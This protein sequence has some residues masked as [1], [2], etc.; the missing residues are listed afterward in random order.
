MQFSIFTSKRAVSS[1]FGLFSRII[2]ICAFWLLTLSVWGQSAGFNNTFIILS[3]NG[4]ANT[5]Y[6][7]NAATG[8]ADFN[9]ANLGS[10]AAGTNNLIFKGAEHNVFKC[11]GADLTSTRVYYRIYLTS[12][13]NS[14][15]NFISNNIPF[16]SGFNNGCGGQD[17]VWLKNDYSTNLLSGLAPGAYTI[18]VYSD[19]STTLGDKFASNNGNNYT[20]TFTIT[21]NYYSKSTGNLELTSSW[22]TN[23]DGTGNAPANFTTAGNTFNIRNNATPTIGASWTVSGTGSKIVV[24]DGTNACNFT[25]ASTF[26]VTSPNTDISNNGTI[27]R[28]SSVVQSLGSLNVLAGGTYDHNFATGSLPNATWAA[29]STLLV[30]ADLQSNNFGGVTFGN[31]TFRNT[32]GTTMF[33]GT[34]ALSSTIAG[35]LNLE[36]TGTIIM[37]SQLSANGTLTVNGNVTIS[38]NSIFRIESVALGSGSNTKTLLVLGNY[39]QSN[40]TMDLSTNTSTTMTARFAILEVRGDF[41]HT[42]GTL[43]ENAAGASPG[44]T[45]RVLL[46]KT[47]GTQTLESTGQ[48]GSVNFNVAGSNAQCVVAATKTFVLGAGNMTVANGSSATDLLVDGT[49]RS[50]STITTT[51][52]VTFSSTGT[53]EH[54]FTTTAGTIPT[55]TW[56]SGSTCAIVGY[57]S[58]AVTINSS[59]G[60]SFSNFT[61]NCASQSVAI[62]LLGILTTVNGNFVLQDAGTGSITYNSNSPATPILTIGGNCTI[63]ASINLNNG[64]ST[65]TFNIGGNFSHTGGTISRAGAGVTTFNFNKSSG[66]QTFTQSGGTITA[67]ANWNVGTGTSTNTVQLSSNVNLGTGTGTF[68]VLGNAT[69]DA[70]TNVLSGSAA[71]TFNSGATIITA[72]ASGI[73]GSITLSGTR[74][75]NAATNYTFNGIAAQV[76]GAAVT[77]A[78]NLILNNSAGLNLSANTSVTGTVTLTNGKLTLDAFDLTLGSAASV[79][80]ATSTKYIVTNSTGQLKKSALTTAFSFPVG[81]S[82]Y[83]PISIT[84]S[85]TSDTYGIIV[86][87]GAVANATVSDECVNRRWF[88]TEVT[89]GGGNLTVSPQYSTG[90]TGA[91][92]S[93]ESQ[94]YV[95]LYVPTNWT[96]TAATISGSNPFNASAS[97]F[98]QSL[99]SSSYFAIGNEGIYIAAPT[100]T[101]TVA[102]SSITNTTASSGGET[103]TGSSITSKGVVWHTS[104]APTVA[105]STKTNDGTGSTNFTSS[106]TSLSP[107]TFYYLR[108]YVTNAAGTG[109]GDEKTFRTLSNPAT[110][111]ASSLIATATS[112]SNID[113][114]WNAATFPSSGATNKGYLLLR[115]AAPNTPSLGNSNGAAPTA[116]ANSTI[117][118]SVIA[119]NATSISN[120]GLAGS[121]QYNYLLIPYTWDGTNATTYNYLTASAPTANATTQSGSTPPVLTTN[122]A[123]SV[124]STTTALNGEIT[125]DGG[126]SVTARGFVYSTSDNTPTIGEGSVND[127]SSGSGIGVFSENVSS[128][129]PNTTYYYQ[130]YATNTSGTSYGGVI[131]FTTLKAEPSAQ[132][133]SLVFSSV[134]TTSFNTAFTAATGSPDGYLVIRSTS[135]SLSADPVDGTTYTSGNSLG[136]GTVVSVGSTISGISNTSLSAG[137]TYYT[138]VFAYNNSGSN[139]DYR[140]TSPLSASTITLTDAPATPTFSSITTSGFTVDWTATTGASSYKLDV[141]TA[142]NFATFVSG[143]QDLTVNTNSQAVT[144]LSANTLYYVRVRAVNASGTSA[145]STSGNTPTLSN[146]P[147]VGTASSIT[148]S[149]LT[150]NWTAP[151]SQ[152]AVTFTYTAELSTASD[153]STI[154]ST[155][156]SIA[157]GTISNAFSSLAEGTTY[158]YRIKAV[159]SAGSSAWSSVSVGATTLS[160][161]ISLTYL[162]TSVNENFDAMS[163]STTLPSGW[164]IHASAPSPS[165]SSASTTVTQEASTGTPTAGGTYNWGTSTSERAVGAMTSGSFGSPNQL[166]VFTKNN[167]GS[168][169]TNFLIG[170][171]AERYRRNSAAASVNFYYSTNGTTW[172]EVT[173]GQI[174]SSNFPTGSSSYTFSTPLEIERTFIISGLTIASA[175][176]FYLRWDINTTGASSQG[177]G[178]DDISIKPCGTVSAPT[179]SNQ[180]FCS[181]ASPTVASLTA[182]GTSI[183]WYSAPSGGTA[184]NSSTALTTATTYYATQ[185]DG[186]CESVSRTAVVVTIN[187]T[188]SVPTG[189]ATQIF[190]STSSPTVNELSA[191]GTSIQWYEASTGGSALATNTSL[192]NS[193]IYYAT[194]TVSGCESTIRLAVT[195]SLV[196]NGTWLG[197][198]STDWNTASN[199]CGGV[200]T[201]STNVVI[202]SGA[203]NYPN[204]ST[205][206]DGVANSITINSGASLTIGG[207]E[208]LTI[209]DGG[210]FTNN[211]TFTAGSGTTLTFAG[212]GSIVGTATFNNITTSGALT[213]SATTTINGAL[214]INS[215][216]TIATNSPIFGASS[217]LQYNFGGG[218]AGRRNAGLEWPASNGPSNLTITNGS[219]IQLTGDRSL[220]GNVTVTNGALQA[221]GGRSLTMNGSTQTFTISTSSG[222]AVYGTDNGFGNDLSLVIANG[223]V[224]TLTG[225]ATSSGDDEKKFL[226][227]TVNAGG[228]LSLSRGILC[229]YGTFTV[230]GTLRI[231][232]NGYIQSTSG[233]APTYG[234]ASNLIYNTGNTFGRGLEWSSTSGAGYPNNV[235]I[236]NNTILNLGNGGTA[237]ARQCA[238]SLTVDNGSTLS[239]NI[240]A[241]SQALTIKGKYTNNGTTILSAV[242]GGDLK[243]EGDM[244]DNGTFTAN[245]RA[246]FF[247]GGNN[248]TVNSSSNPLDIDVMRIG[249]TGGEV[250]LSQN[251]LVDETNDPIQFTTTTSILNLNGYTATFGKANAASSI[252]MNASSRIKGSS[253][254]SI[255]ILGTGSFGTIYFDQTTLGA[256]NALNNFTINRTSSGSVVLGN[257][258]AVT[259]ALTII[260]GNVNLGTAIHSAGSLS[261]GGTSQTTSSSYGGTGSPAATVNTTYFAATAGVV[262]IGT[263]GSYSLTSTSAVAC[264]GSGATVTLSNSTTSQLPVGNYTV[265]Y[266]LTGANTGSSSSVMTIAAAGSGSFATTTIANSGA[267]TITINYI[268]SGC[269]SAISSGNTA[270]I[271]VNALPTALSLTGSSYCPT[272]SAGGTV[273]SSSSTA[274]VSYQLFNADNTAI[275]EPKPGTGNALA[276]TNISQGNNYYVV[277]TNIASSCVSANSNLVTVT[278]SISGNFSYYIDTDG[279]NYGAGSAVLGCSATTP[280]GYA[281]NAGDC[282]NNNSAVYPTATE[283]CGNNIDE[284]CSG[285][286]DDMP[287]FYRTIADG[288]WGDVSTWE[289]ACA[290]GAYTTAAYAPPSY[291]TGMVNIRN[292]HD[293][294][295]PANGTTYQTGTLDIDEGG[296]L[297][298][299]GNDYITS[300]TTATVSPIAKLTVTLLIDNAGTLNIGHQASLVQTSTTATNTGN[301]NIHVESKLTGTN[302][303]TAPNGRYWYIG[304]PMNNTSAGQ[305]FD[306]QALVWTRLWRYKADNNSWAVVIHSQTNTNSTL[307]LI[308][309]MGYLYRAGSNKTITYTGTAA[310]NLNN[311]IES[312]LLTPTTDATLVPVEGYNSIGYK[313][314]ANPYPS[315]V[316][317]RLVTRTGLNVSYWIR[318]ATNTAYEAYNATTNVSTSPSGQTTRYIP[319]MQGFWVY[320]FNNTPSLRIDNTDRVHADNVL[321]TP[322]INQ[323]VRLKLNDGKSCDYAVVYE[324]DLA[325]NDYEET[326]TD[327]MFDYDFHQLYTMEGEHEL[328]LNGLLNATAKGSVDMGM[329]VPNNGPY[330]IEATDLGVEEDVIL[331]DKFNHTFQ[332][333]KVNPIYTFTSNAGTFNNRF[334]LHFTATESVAVTETVGETEGVKVFNT[335]NKQVK[336][337][338]SNTT[339]EYQG[340]TVKVYDAVGNLIERKNMTSNELYLDLDIANGI[341]MVEVTGTNKTFTKKVFIGK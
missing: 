294:T 81:N 208:T 143:Y 96:K 233:V 316:D 50:A 34:S 229:K 235:Q 300:P 26:V 142:S 48:T 63:N 313:F 97:G 203:S 55:A 219:W 336:V 82:A 187:N 136:G 140:T 329:V 251:L 299:L 66:T 298:L 174:A 338:V 267:T 212:T 230:N 152:G 70:G 74:T 115:A 145:N 287:S 129:T 25:I 322:V 296:S 321:H 317:W 90:E 291:Y 259:N 18:Q 107:E 202:N 261:L 4:G 42:G 43:T 67:T 178:I 72:H 214:T 3:L 157:S 149:G 127:Q 53:Y 171:T 156:S 282:N 164:R 37:S 194:Q 9:G 190:C 312:N 207:T 33:T 166:L 30:S 99:T 29:T 320:A 75:Y 292:N 271:T 36:G 118:S 17:Q 228:T 225:D 23:T 204:L 237:V 151:S 77:A 28:T 263:C 92:Y 278:E 270:T 189:T 268:R 91:A 319:P 112:S 177:I 245:G 213:P 335:S 224:T 105:L 51:G 130:A 94:V 231:N 333:L 331:E 45:T 303:T 5:Y 6:D 154:T 176:D 60:Q 293:V 102:A 124:L 27:T 248:Q 15:V 88:I 83:N 290:A 236:S 32:A 211:G 323:V 295:I 217:T 249:K 179:S 165:W 210:S 186:G 243:L 57:T 315:H 121:T 123:S 318:N 241:M 330:T 326:D 38:G 108:A 209:T 20:A 341:Y 131:S 11:G 98:N 258:V 234:N 205:G 191:T 218:F 188:P 168:T 325:A 133:T 253:T 262:N 328:S 200:P 332:D 308:P 86:S 324:N 185:T 110:A 100:V 58:T 269:V 128:L 114:T 24:G 147:T 277:G 61:W 155:V 247:E 240:N 196:N 281:V 238:G 283:L 222:G 254:S 340:A 7:L 310:A 250:I 197:S 192:V 181:A 201:S 138:F 195:A 161:S 266:T 54:N 199:W 288:N 252:T 116:G 307:K 101:T 273:S 73:N 84:N 126:A 255:E 56:S 305:F 21:G 169:I 122:A 285:T 144:G 47:S 13:G 103:I 87:D 314:V 221:S 239:L 19:A 158:Y 302:N 14:G 242:I 8:N 289:T 46:S 106:V 119:E 10:F 274:G 286:S 226:N 311:D 39:V 297:T 95:G 134:T 1:F 198:T 180:S 125:S 170:Y 104:T 167:T 113:L 284:N 109:Y 85:G 71:S 44:M 162:G 183:Q 69:L 184:L 120:S 64:T 163:S 339:A 93:T 260:N 137:T 220:L 49:L 153:F 280:A 304:S 89:S 79:S 223:S 159:N 31:V 41:S 175:A 173:D 193:T 279:D 309:G 117:V 22:G 80:S 301:G 182:T 216:G 62:N 160:T 132:P 276:W 135:A 265:F 148:T 111:Q 59:F 139:I 141:S 76:S 334:V 275:G 215:G 35:N 306:N 244:D 78:N 227:V 65:P 337:W 272:T 257:A 327:K 40:G 68:T 256:S 172:T 264:L 12:A 150:A 232:A 16:S 206:A 146:A 52:A 2:T 246:I